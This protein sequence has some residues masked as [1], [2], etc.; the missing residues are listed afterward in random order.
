M[1]SSFFGFETAKRSMLASQNVL[2]IIGHNISNQHIPGYSRQRVNLNASMPIEY[3][4]IGHTTIPGQ[5]G[6]GVDMHSITRIRDRFLDEQFRNEYKN[7][8]NWEI[9]KDTLDKL[10][11]IFPEPSDTGLRKVLENFW[12]SWA[13]FSKDSDKNTGRKL[14]RQN[15]IALTEAIN[16]ASKQI[17]DI[18]QGLD[19]SL[20]MKIEDVNSILKTISTLNNEI[21]RVEKMGDHANDLRDE[22]D[23]LTDELSKMMNITVSEGPEGYNIS[24]GKVNLLSGTEVNPVTKESIEESFKSGDLSSGELAGLI[25]SRDTYVHDYKKQL[26]DIA[27]TIA[28]GEITITIPKGSVL[29]EGTVLDGVTYTGANRTL[30]EDLTVTVKGLNGLHQLG[31]INGNPPEAGGP[32]FTTKDGSDVI[33]AENICLNPDIIN[34]P[35][36]IASSMATEGTGADEK[37]IS[38]NNTLAKLMAQLKDTKFTFSGAG[39][40]IANSTINDFYGSLVGQLGVQSKEATR[41]YENEGKLVVQADTRRTSVSGVVELEE[42]MEM[43]KY[44]HS[45]N[46]AARFMTTYDEILN[47]L[48]NGT[49][50]AGR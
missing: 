5:M 15:A 12:D 49:G 43:V 46:A 16:Q 6:T 22:R 17:K 13:E 47:K 19:K 41:Q 34:D 32:F 31:Y 23:R 8:G 37:L 38:G 4:G 2:N 11:G 36:K 14:I 48:I 21:T 27:N 25:T 29:P 30:T 26:D 44:N 7:L 28:N 39:S 3:P 45:F 40:G 1:R 33:T 35:N 24:M 20:N 9:K 50:T 10:E 42:M 18:S